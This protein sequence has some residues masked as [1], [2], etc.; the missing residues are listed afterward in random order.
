MTRRAFFAALAALPVFA[1][2][3]PKPKKLT[4]W[5]QYRKGRLGPP[6]NFDWYVPQSNPREDDGARMGA[7]AVAEAAELAERNLRCVLK[8]YE[9]R[10]G[11][12]RIMSDP[13]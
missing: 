7:L 13:A 9:P 2:L 12:P 10:L 1:R 5:E 3:L 4:L 8:A 6:N 11:L